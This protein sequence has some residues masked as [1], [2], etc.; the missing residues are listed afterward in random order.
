[1]LE[2]EVA[3]YRRAVAWL[4]TQLEDASLQTIYTEVWK[5]ELLQHAHKTIISHAIHKEIEQRKRRSA[6]R[7]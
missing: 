7:N 1:M 2:D 4:A 5:D 6:A 3:Y